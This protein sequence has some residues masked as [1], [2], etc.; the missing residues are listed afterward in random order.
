MSFCMMQIASDYEW[1]IFKVKQIQ[2]NYEGVCIKFI[3]TK[4]F[5]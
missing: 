2:I 4:Q 5:S 1:K 3:L